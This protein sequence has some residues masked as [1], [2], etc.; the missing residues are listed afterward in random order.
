MSIEK[1][2]TTEIHRVY[3]WNT[4][5]RKD[6]NQQQ[7][8]SD[9][10]DGFFNYSI[11]NT[12][13]N[14]AYMPS[15]NKIFWLSDYSQNSG[16]YKLLWNYSKTGRRLKI[17]EKHT[18][19]PTKE[20]YK[21]EGD[22]E[23]QHTLIKD[24]GVENK[25]VMVFERVQGGVTTKYI[26]EEINKYIEINFPDL[27]NN[28]VRLNIDPIISRDFM[29]Y[30]Y[31]MKRIPVANIYV[32]KS[33]KFLIDDEDMSIVDE[34]GSMRDTIKLIIK[35]NYK[36]SLS[37]KFIEWLLK[38]KKDSKGKVQRIVIEGEGNIGPIKLDT[39]SIKLK[40]QLNISLD[41]DG[42]IDSDDIF[43]K[44]EY[45]INHEFDDNLVDSFLLKN[46][47]AILQDTN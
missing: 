6:F 34:E 7:V 26:E 47:T 28:G 45:Y 3:L 42:N 35:A 17:I 33:V 14:N 12:N 19:S 32:D 31:K 23:K 13:N 29:G 39:E 1:P 36:E 8:L 11:Q 5:T 40:R 20:K 4:I 41:D 2:R 10:L 9:I 16:R 18:L 44:Y 22:L 15:S 27:S 46:R 21:D 43:D 37:R 24:Y 30:L 38:L 25:A